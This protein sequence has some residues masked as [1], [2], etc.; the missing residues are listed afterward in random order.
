MGII[1][2]ILTIVVLGLAFFIWLL[3]LHLDE[4]TKMFAKIVNLVM[5]AAIVLLILGIVEKWW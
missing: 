5:I 2:T 4:L 1:E 3:S